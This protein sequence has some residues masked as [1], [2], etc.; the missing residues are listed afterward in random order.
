MTTCTW[1]RDDD[2]NYET[3][4]DNMHCFIDGCVKDN[5]YNFCPYCG[6]SVEEA[7]DAT[8]EN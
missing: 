6:C 7:K 8:D 4:C 2:G 1:T 5:H 3:E